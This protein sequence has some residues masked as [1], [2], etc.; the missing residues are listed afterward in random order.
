MKPQTAK[1]S[2]PIMRFFTPELYLRFNSADE[3][4]ADEANEAWE[5]AVASYQKH[6]ERLREQMPEEV[7]KLADSCFHDFIL[8]A[9]DPRRTVLDKAKQGSL[10]SGDTLVILSIEQESRVVSLY[11]V[12]GDHIRA[13]S[14]PAKWP[15]ST[16]HVH[17]LYDEIDVEPQAAGFVHRILFSDGRTLEIPFVSVI[18]HDV[19]LADVRG[20]LQQ[21]A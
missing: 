18:K 14:V 20:G 16:D 15:F 10:P 13:A 4:E 2:E 9:Y 5:E 19:P 6:L 7:K 21:S 11:Y 12:L 8:L 17:W 1:Q 3:Q